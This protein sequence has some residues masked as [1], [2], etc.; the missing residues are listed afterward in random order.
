VLQRFVH[1]GTQWCRH[2]LHYAKHG[3]IASVRIR[4]GIYDK[5]MDTQQVA[6]FSADHVFAKRQVS[7]A[8]IYL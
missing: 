6:V 4:A 2:P 1:Q 3:A 5:H 8:Q 7:P